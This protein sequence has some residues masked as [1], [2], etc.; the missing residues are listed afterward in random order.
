MKIKVEWQEGQIRSRVFV[1]KEEFWGRSL[2]SEAF[3]AQNFRVEVSEK[4]TRD[5]STRLSVSVPV[6]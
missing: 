4:D 2:A 3:V 6:C 1:R 5:P